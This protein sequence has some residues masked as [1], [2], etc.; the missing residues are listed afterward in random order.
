MDDE[1]IAEATQDASTMLHMA[2]PASKYLELNQLFLSAASM[3][4]QAQAMVDSAETQMKIAAADM[5]AERRKLMSVGQGERV[6]LVD[7]GMELVAAPED[8]VETLV[9][10]QL[11]TREEWRA[12]KKDLGVTSEK[13]F[14]IARELRSKKRRPITEKV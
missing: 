9:M 5:D 12:L 8:G 6:D 4:A 13:G 7:R 1:M 10:S 3:V 2:G 11:L 14:S